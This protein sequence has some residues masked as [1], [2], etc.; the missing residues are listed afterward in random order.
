MANFKSL[1]V[2]CMG[3]PSIDIF[4]AVLFLCVVQHTNAQS[5]E[6]TL[7]ELNDLLVNTV[8]DDLFTPPI[9]S[10]IYTY[11]NIA[12]YECI[13][14]DDKRQPQFSGKLKGLKPLPP[15]PLQNDNFISAA[16]AYSL[17]AQ[18]LVGSEYKIEQWRTAFLDSI[19]N[20]MDTTILR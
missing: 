5:K 4:I 17:V 2:L 16:V 1:L 18:S 15:P 7:H 12:F 8:M 13:R 20:I 3:R 14:F 11:P 9:A 19:T 6:R 10:R